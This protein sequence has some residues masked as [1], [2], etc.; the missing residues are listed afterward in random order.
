MTTAN[1]SPP[2]PPTRQFD[3][4]EVRFME[5]A[6]DLA[7]EALYAQEVPIGCVFVADNERVI[8]RTRNRTN[9]KRNVSTS[10]ASI[11]GKM[12]QC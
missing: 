8:A 1:N 6:F 4:R 7:E 2:S 9:E 5:M 12:V 10:P 11:D 3:E